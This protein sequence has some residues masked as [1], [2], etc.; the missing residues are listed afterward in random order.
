MFARDM[1]LVSAAAEHNL[2]TEQQIKRQLLYIQAAAF[3]LVPS[4]TLF[5]KNTLKLV[6]GIA[7]LQFHT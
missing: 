1:L 7:L 5:L 3:F 4:V 6:L 2:L